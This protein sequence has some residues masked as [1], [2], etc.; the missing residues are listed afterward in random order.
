MYIFNIINNNTLIAI[1]IK[2]CKAKF[3]TSPKIVPLAY[4]KIN[5]EFCEHIR[6]STEF[7][8]QGKYH[9]NGKNDE[10]KWFIT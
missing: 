9:H 2:Y 8:L 4:A 1:K 10:I 7:G 3:R 5:L 6:K